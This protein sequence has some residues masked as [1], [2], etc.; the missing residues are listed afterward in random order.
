MANETKYANAVNVAA[1]IESGV[2]NA[3]RSALVLTPLCRVVNFTPGS[4]SVKLRKKGTVTAGAG[5]ESTAPSNTA[6][7]QSSP[8]TL[9]VQEAVV[10]IDRSDRNKYFTQMSLDE[11]VEAITIA[12]AEKVE[13]DALALFNTLTNQVGSTTVDLT[14]DAMKEAAYTLRLNNNDGTYIYVMH[15]TQ[16]NDVDTDIIAGTGI[17]NVWANPSVDVSLL[18][19]TAAQANGSVGFFLGNE[20][21]VTTN[22]E[23]INTNAD[24]QGGIIVPNKCIALGQ[25][26]RGIQVEIQRDAKR[27]SDEIT[28]NVYYDVELAEDVAGCGIVSD[29]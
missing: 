12:V 16:V 15:P 10:L 18:G 22:T 2:M 5:T 14:P 11:I 26:G 28:A 27:R 25:D 29:Q 13:T 3:L 21:R 23:S 17:G 19:Q 20:V 4:D 8:A 7:S 1:Y 9:Q 24:W 6:Y